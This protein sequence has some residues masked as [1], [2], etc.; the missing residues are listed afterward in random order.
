MAVLCTAQRSAPMSTEEH[1]DDKTKVVTSLLQ[2][3]RHVRAIICI[4][5]RPSRFHKF[6]GRFYRTAPLSDGTSRT[7]QLMILIRCTSAGRDWQVSRATHLVTFV[8]V[9]S[10]SER[11]VNAD[12]GS[13]DRNIYCHAQFWRRYSYYSL[14]GSEPKA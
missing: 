9:D 12:V 11:T 13:E 7:V 3:V 4:W 2:W 1:W 6:L 14:T 10:C 5:S 8:G